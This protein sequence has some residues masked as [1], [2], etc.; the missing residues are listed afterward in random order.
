MET[1]DSIIA[2][3]PFFKGLDEAYLRLIAG[4]GSNVVFEAGQ[5]LF[6]E[7]ED[8]D[9]FY[10]VRRGR[11]AI[12]IYV[13][14][15]GPVVLETV[16][17]GEMVG[18]S[19]LFPPYRRQFDARAVEVV[20]ATMFDGACLRAKCDQDAAMGYELMKRLAGLFSRRLQAAR[21]QLLDMYGPSTG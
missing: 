2:T 1:L 15:R 16:R 7:G 11:V 4:C 8:A 19:W 17:E 12:E 9:R 6:R 13:P 3:H 18:W 21:L 10:A 14:Q 5:Y 20:R